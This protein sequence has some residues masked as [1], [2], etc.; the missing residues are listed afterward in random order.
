MLASES[1]CLDVNLGSALSYVGKPGQTALC[2]SASANGKWG[3]RGC[4][5]ANELC[6]HSEHGITLGKY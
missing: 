1:E 5:R 3:G 4:R 2:D 6:G